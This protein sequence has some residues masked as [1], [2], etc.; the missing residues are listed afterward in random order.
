MTEAGECE[1]RNDPTNFGTDGGEVAT[2]G[3]EGGAEELV[4]LVSPAL[5][6][7][8]AVVVDDERDEHAAVGNSTK[9]I[10]AVAGS[11]PRVRNMVEQGEDDVL[12]RL[13]PGGATTGHV[14]SNAESGKGASEN[15]R[16][17][18]AVAVATVTAS[19]RCSQ[20]VALSGDE[21]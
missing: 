18:D 2:D 6:A 8:V 9:L 21:G 19:C 16:V 3:G 15:P 17:V 4:P 10:A 1:T 11:R 14:K 5:L 20:V 12:V 7:V 13:V